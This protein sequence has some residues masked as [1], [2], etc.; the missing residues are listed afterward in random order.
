M[1][2]D[3]T[4]NKVTISMKR[5]IALIPGALATPHLWKHQEDTLQ[6]KANIHYLDVLNYAK[7]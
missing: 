3:R 2:I 4:V 7:Q 1:Y 5:D 6:S